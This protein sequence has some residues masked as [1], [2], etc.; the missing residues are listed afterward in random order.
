MTLSAHTEDATLV[1]RRAQAME[2]V[3]RPRGTVRCAGKPAF[4]SQLARD[5]GCLLDLDGG[6]DRWSCLPAVLREGD[7]EHLPDFL[8]R[9]GREHVLIDAVAG[10]SDMP[11][12]WVQEAAADRGCLYEAWGAERIRNGYRLANAKDLLR[13]AGWDCPLGDRVRLLAGLDEAGSLAVAECLSAFR[14]TRP[15]AGLAA[16]VLRRFVSIELDEAP[17]GPE[18]QVRRWRD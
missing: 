2:C 15:I 5:L 6:V 3:Y 8:A 7:D 17:I 18:T 12:G 9:R 16:L 4:R 10:P 11:H 14:E 13:Y 1:A